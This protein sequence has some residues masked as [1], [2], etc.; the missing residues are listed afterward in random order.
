MANEEILIGQRVIITSKDS[1]LYGC[2]GIVEQLFPDQT[3]AGIILDREKTDPLFFA[4]TEFES[5][6]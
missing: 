2:V 3:G 4:L 5:T 6:N 1:K